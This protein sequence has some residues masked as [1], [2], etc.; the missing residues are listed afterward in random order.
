MSHIEEGKTTIKLTAL[1][2]ALAQGD[3]N[4]AQQHP[5]MAL[6]RQ[7][8]TMVAQARGGEVGT[9]YADY[10]Y[11]PQACN[12]NL[13]LTIPGELPRGIGLVVDLKTGTLTFKGDPWADGGH[14]ARQVRRACFEEVQQQIVQHYVV[15]AHAAALRRMKAQVSTQVVDQQVV[16][17]GVFHG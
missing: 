13:A 15:L 14:A 11:Q 9:T 4:A 12:T 7:A 5:C 8:V 17:T 6:L 10:G 3:T 16:I 1:A 2:T